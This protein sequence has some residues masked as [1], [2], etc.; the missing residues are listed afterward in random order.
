[1]CHSHP[2]LPAG[3]VPALCPPRAWA[4]LHEGWFAEATA[5]PTGARVIHWRAQAHGWR[6]NSF[7]RHIRTVC[8]VMGYYDI[9]ANLFC[10]TLKA[11]GS[12]E[13]AAA[14]V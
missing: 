7:P 3:D 10:P 11:T 13:A 12:K 1:V 8:Q 9:P 14:F 2:V 6:H 4:S 5:L